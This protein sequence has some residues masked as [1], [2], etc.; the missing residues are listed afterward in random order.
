MSY[1]DPHP[2]MKGSQRVTQTCAKCGGDGWLPTIVDGGTCWPCQGTGTVTVLVSSA[3]A[4]ARRQA[5][6][7]ADLADQAATAGDR[8]DTAKTALKA[9]ISDFD[10]AHAG[11]LGHVFAYAAGQA[12]IDYR[13]RGNLDQ[14][15]DDYDYATRRRFL[16]RLLGPNRYPGR[17]ATCTQ[18]VAAGAGVRGDLPDRYLTWCVSHVPAETRDL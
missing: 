17:C 9:R 10:Q 14:A 11:Q 5:K 8:Y 6:A 4:R 1:V 15:V 3:R 12:V 16:P 7:A 2:G 13:D 18:P